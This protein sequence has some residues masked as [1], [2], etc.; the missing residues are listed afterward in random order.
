MLRDILNTLFS[1]TELNL[2][3]SRL[4]FH[5]NAVFWLNFLAVGGPLHCTTRA[6][7][8]NS[9]IKRQNSSSH[10]P[11]IA[12]NIS[13]CE[14]QHKAFAASS[15]KGS[16]SDQSRRLLWDTVFIIWRKSFVTRLLNVSW[17]AFCSQGENASFLRGFSPL[18]ALNKDCELPLSLKCPIFRAFYC[19]G[20][21][22]LETEGG[23]SFKSTAK[24]PAPFPKNTPSSWEG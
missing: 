6:I 8:M 16:W 2:L 7:S 14:R 23:E 24:S 12:E 20:G 17:S 21:R 10:F 1:Q 9:K 15:D 19:L 5:C 13:I 4:I 18:W 11:L 22:P 3:L